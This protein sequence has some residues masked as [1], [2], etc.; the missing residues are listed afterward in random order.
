MFIRQKLTWV[1]FYPGRTRVS[2]YRVNGAL[3][4]DEK[5]LFDDVFMPMLSEALD[6]LGE[7]SLHV[8]C[9]HEEGNMIV[10]IQQP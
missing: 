2:L 3:N 6:S 8:E 1:S 10:E 9:F 7:G 4:N 5:Q